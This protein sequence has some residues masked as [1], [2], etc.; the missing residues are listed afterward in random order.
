MEP[1]YRSEES[2]LNLS[3]VEAYTAGQNMKLYKLTEFGRE[4]ISSLK[5]R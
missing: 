3:I 2:L 4:I 1:R 5:G